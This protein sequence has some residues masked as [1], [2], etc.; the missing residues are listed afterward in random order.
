MKINELKNP[1]SPV[2]EGLENVIGDYGAAAIRSMAT[3]GMTIKSQLSKDFFIKDFVGDA[4]AS[5]DAALKSGVLNTNK[6][7]PSTSA[8][9]TDNSPPAPD[10]H[11]P[12]TQQTSTESA[13]ITPKN[14]KQKPPQSS[15]SRMWDIEHEHFRYPIR[16]N[17]RSASP[18]IRSLRVDLDR[19]AEGD[20]ES[21]IAAVNK[22]LKF[23]TAD[24]KNNRYFLTQSVCLG[25]SKLLNEYKLTWTNLGLRARLYESSKNSVACLSRCTP[26]PITTEEFKKLNR[27]F[28]NIMN[29]DEEDQPSDQGTS[30]VNP[31]NTKM[32][33]ADFIT[34][35]LDKYM[36]PILWKDSPAAPKVNAIIQQVQNTYPE[37]SRDAL[38]SLG[39]AM[40]AISSTGDQLPDGLANAVERVKQ[41]GKP[42]S[43]D[44][45]TH[46]KTRRD[47]NVQTTQP[48]PN[49]TTPPNT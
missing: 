33:I 3:P 43:S 13:I 48:S 37:H 21:R 6:N 9:T 27:I 44:A 7:A 5:L 26:T 20:N 35:W 47:R 25:I 11:G 42:G 8:K 45:T 4:T 19:L 12:N 41:Q 2:D 10:N 34:L 29:I 49:N 15:N 36:H 18:I 31:S 38:I 1:K 40:F 22:I 14:P 23:A 24:K 30:Q 28:E 32:S 46:T 17:E 16:I 39:N